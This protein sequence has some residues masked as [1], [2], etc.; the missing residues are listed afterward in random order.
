MQLSYLRGTVRVF[1]AKEKADESLAMLLMSEV[2]FDGG[3]KPNP[4][5]AIATAGPNSRLL[6]RSFTKYRG[7]GTTWTSKLG[8]FAGTIH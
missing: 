1:R 8:R 4:V 6:G 7:A 3:V 2:S 5:P